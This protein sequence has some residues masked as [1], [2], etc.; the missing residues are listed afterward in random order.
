MYNGSKLCKLVIQSE[1][2]VREAGVHVL[3]KTGCGCQGKKPGF[4]YILLQHCMC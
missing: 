3:R 4:T 1:S 2:D